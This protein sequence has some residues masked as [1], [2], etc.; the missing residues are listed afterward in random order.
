MNELFGQGAVS[1]VDVRDRFR[2]DEFAAWLAFVT[3]RSKQEEHEK[4]Q[5]EH[6]KTMESFAKALR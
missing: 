3:E 6:D 2:G 4:A 1:Y 5:E